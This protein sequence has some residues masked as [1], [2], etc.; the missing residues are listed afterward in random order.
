MNNVKWLDMIFHSFYVELYMCKN[1]FY[2]SYFNSPLTLQAPL[3]VTGVSLS[4]EVHK[5]KP[6]LKVTWTALPLS[7]DSFYELQHRIKDTSWEFQ[8]NIQPYSQSYFLRNLVP[9][10]AYNVR[11]RAVY[12]AENGEWSDV[13]TE[14]TFDSELNP[15]HLQLCHHGIM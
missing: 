9:G 12:G 8:V 6:S 11:M 7:P 4:K 2:L 14:T 13:H 3:R 1:C 15:L 10:T 5:R